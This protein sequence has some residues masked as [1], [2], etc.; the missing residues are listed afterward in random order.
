MRTLIVSDTKCERTILQMESPKRYILVMSGKGGVGKS[1][2]SANL[3]RAIARRDGSCGLLDLDLTGPSIPG[4]FGVRDGSIGNKNGRMVPYSVGNLEIISLGMMLA[5]PSDAIIWRGPRKNGMIDSFFKLPDWKSST[6]VV[7]LPPGTSD[8]HLTTLEILKG[9]TKVVIVTTPSP[10]SI[11]DVKKG[12]NLCKMEET[13]IV[14]VVENFS[15][16]V[17]PCCGEITPFLGESAAQS[18]SSEMGIPLLGTIPFLPA[19]A[20]AADNGQTPEVLIPIFNE[21]VEKI[22]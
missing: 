14:G 18:L 5:D 4:L 12:I 17:C 20:T 16:V 9:K 15:G 11:A 8:E 22:K 21:L 19:A 6:I 2:V 1:T 10:L 7:D 3:A 13:E